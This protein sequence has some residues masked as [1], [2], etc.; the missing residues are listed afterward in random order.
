MSF[1]PCKVAFISRGDSHISGN[2]LPLSECHSERERV[3]PRGAPAAPTFSWF[4]PAMQINADLSS[5]RIYR[6][7]YR[8]SHKQFLLFQSWVKVWSSSNLFVKDLGL[9]EKSRRAFLVQLIS[10][11]CYSSQHRPQDSVGWCHLPQPRPRA[12]DR[13]PAWPSE[14]DP[15][16]E[17]AP[18]PHRNPLTFSASKAQSPHSVLTGAPTSSTCTIRG[19]ARLASL[20]SVLG[21]QI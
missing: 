11:D 20:F 21:P 16:L 18:L 17:I 1:L 15:I 7:I 3:G 10:G 8:H 14:S 9:W 19:A 12:E 13:F 6:N 2:C 5:E 4:F